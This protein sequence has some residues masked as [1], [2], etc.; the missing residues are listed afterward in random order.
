MGVSWALDLTLQGELGENGFIY[1]F[2]IVKSLTREALKKSL[3]HCLLVS[4]DVQKKMRGAS[5]HWQLNEKWSY[6]CPERCVYQFATS[7][8]SKVTIEREIESIISQ[9]L[10]EP[11]IRVTATLRELIIPDASLFQYTHGIVGHQG[12]CQR[13]LHGHSSQLEIIVDDVRRKDIEQNIISQ[14]FSKN[15]HL[16]NRFQLQHTKAWEVGQRGPIGEIAKIYYEGSKGNYEVCL[17]ADKVLLLPEETSI[18]CLTHFL[19]SH[20]DKLGEAK[21]SIRVTCREGLN[22]GATAQL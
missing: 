4:A 16:T 20:V 3:D 2:S 9:A 12:Y 8:I 7:D 18:E 19:A 17:P 14:V 22:K 21:K 15:I 13:P 11:D 1:D 10:R 6:Q 5:E